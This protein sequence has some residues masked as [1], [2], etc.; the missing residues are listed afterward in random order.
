LL[1]AQFSRSQGGK[2]TVRAPASSL[3]IS[4]FRKSETFHD[5]YATEIPVLQIILGIRDFKVARRAE[6]ERVQPE[7]PAFPRFLG[8]GR[9]VEG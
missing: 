2:G 7:E 5:F 4:L 3:P 6:V 9:S 8:F 1:G